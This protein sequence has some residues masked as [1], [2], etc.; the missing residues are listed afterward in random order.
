MERILEG[1]S[2]MQHLAAGGNMVGRP[3][4]SLVFCNAALRARDAGA[5]IG[6]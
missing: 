1:V 5:D 6:F 4:Y 3:N 2:L